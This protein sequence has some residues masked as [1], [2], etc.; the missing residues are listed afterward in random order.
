MNKLFLIVIGI[1]ATCALVYDAPENNWQPIGGKS[2]EGH[3][4][5]TSGQKEKL[6]RAR[7]G[8]QP[9]SY[10]GNQHSS[11]GNYTFQVKEKV[12]MGPYEVW[13]LKLKDGPTHKHSEV[14]MT[15][16]YLIDQLEDETQK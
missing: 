9:A 13:E 15:D 16:P 6:E 5:L 7:N 3:T 2:Y 4:P 8:W 14:D 12:N 11:E 1:V 10:G